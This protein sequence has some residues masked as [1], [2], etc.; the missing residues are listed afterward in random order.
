MCQMCSCVNE[1]KADW[2]TLILKLVDFCNFECSFCRYSSNRHRRQMSL[3]TYK[4]TIQNACEHNIANGCNHLTIIHHGG[5]PLP[6]IRHFSLYI[7]LSQKYLH[8]SV[9]IQ[10]IYI[11]LSS[12]L[13]SYQRTPCSLLCR[14]YGFPAKL[15]L[16]INQL[17]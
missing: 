15:T 3:D 13:V 4:L 8:I 2:V 17:K 14:D 12:Q 16:K 10:K 1:A 6:R 11:S 9:L 7:W 5:E